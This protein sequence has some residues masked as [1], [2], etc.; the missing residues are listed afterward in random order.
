MDVQS[1][2]CRSPRGLSL[3]KVASCLQI[4]H[5]IS[6]EFVIL[7]WCS[8]TPL[9]LSNT[10]QDHH[11][12]SSRLN[13]CGH[14]LSCN[15]RAQLARVSPSLGSNLKIPN[16][17]PSQTPKSIPWTYGTPSLVVNSVLNPTKMDEK[18]W[19]IFQRFFHQNRT[20]SLVC[21]QKPNTRLSPVPPS[22]SL[23]HY[24]S[25]DTWIYLGRYI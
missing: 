19:G 4:P 12:G 10:T 21:P 22:L 9:S 14:H 23:V 1:L 16:L 8:M 7:L 17:E 6:N 3:I 25:L 11:D 24:R 18:K 2:G 15:L 13:H 5:E 20:C